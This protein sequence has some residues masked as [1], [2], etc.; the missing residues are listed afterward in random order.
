MRRNIF[1]RFPVWTITTADW[2]KAAAG[3]RILFH[4]FIIENL[5]VFLTVRSMS[6]W[7]CRRKLRLNNLMAVWNIILLKTPKGWFRKCSSTVRCMRKKTAS[8]KTVGRLRL[9]CMAAYR[10]WR[11][12][13]SSAALPMVQTAWRFQFPTH[14]VRITNM[15]NS[16]SATAR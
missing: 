14:K 2:L 5:P 7:C 16:T 4:A 11:T 8:R 1:F 6:L 9:C 15:S 3:I 10:L 13:C 12:I